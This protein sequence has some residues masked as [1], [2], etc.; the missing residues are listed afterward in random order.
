MKETKGS[1]HAMPVAA[2]SAKRSDDPPE[3]QSERKLHIVREEP[4]PAARQ[5]VQTKSHRR[6]DAPK[7]ML[8]RSLQA[9]LGRQLR[10]IFADVSE[11][12]VPERF[13]KL[14]EAL[15]AREKQR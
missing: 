8:D 12:P 7:G 10:T 2:P 5:D 15:E 11:E 6:P 1:R 3:A 14:L 9:Q 4:D 13:V